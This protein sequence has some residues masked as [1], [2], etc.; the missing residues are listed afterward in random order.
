MVK[1]WKG[2]LAVFLSLF[3]F[4]SIV[5][6]DYAANA[7]SKNIPSVVQQ[8]ATEQIFLNRTFVGLDLKTYIGQCTYRKTKTVDV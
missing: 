8:R 6:L 7:Q 5:F 2:L 3:V 4:V 1:N